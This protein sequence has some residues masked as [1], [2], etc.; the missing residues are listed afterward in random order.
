VAAFQAWLDDDAAVAA[1]TGVTADQVARWK[2][3]VPTLL[4]GVNTSLAGAEAIRGQAQAAIG[5]KA[6]KAPNAR[7]A[8][9]RDLTAWRAALTAGDAKL[10]DLVNRFPAAKQGFDDATTASQDAT[11]RLATYQ[12]QNADIKKAS[13]PPLGGVVEGAVRA[14]AH[15]SVGVP[16]GYPL[17]GSVANI[18]A[19]S[20]PTPCSVRATSRARRRR[21]RRSP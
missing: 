17:T 5:G 13:T 1:A 11:T 3:D 21:R 9:D 6:P 20:S 12:R 18:S 4:Q 7:R 8:G 14:V 16:A 2:T 10:A 15:Q 19:H